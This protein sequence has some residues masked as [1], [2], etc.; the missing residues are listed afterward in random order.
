MMQIILSYYVSP[1]KL[2]VAIVVIAF[3]R[4]SY[5]YILNNYSFYGAIN[6]AISL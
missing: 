1:N 2:I 5:G 3:I 6:R 4:L